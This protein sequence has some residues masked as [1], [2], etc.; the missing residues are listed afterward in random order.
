MS[1][2]KE[3]I[4]KALEQDNP[5]FSAA[6]DVQFNCGVI[7]GL[8]IAGFDSVDAVERVVEYLRGITKN[9]TRDLTKS[10]IGNQLDVL[11]Y[12]LE[13]RGRDLPKETVKNYKLLKRAYQEF[14]RQF[15]Y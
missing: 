13:K 6:R 11:N 1:L 9:Y 10:T 8:R 4:G 7:S 14:F 5:I 3:V 15:S 2:E 12:G